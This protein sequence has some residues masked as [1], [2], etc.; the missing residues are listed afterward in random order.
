MAFVLTAFQF[1]TVS[2]PLVSWRLLLG[3]SAGFGFTSAPSFLQSQVLLYHSFG[4][5]ADFACFGRSPAIATDFANGFS[6][7][8]ILFN[9]LVLP[10]W[11]LLAAVWI[12]RAKG[13]PPTLPGNA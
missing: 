13:R 6:K 1:V 7:S 8:F 2:S 9:V 11:M 10:M 5:R 4:G 12:T 3:V